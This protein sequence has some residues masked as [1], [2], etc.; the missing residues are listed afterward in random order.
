[1]NQTAKDY[2]FSRLKAGI[3]KIE[4]TLAEKLP[5]QLWLL[6]N[7][8]FK[9][10][11]LDFII[12]GGKRLRPVLS[13]IAAEEFGFV[14]EDKF[15]ELFL[16][17]ESFHKFIL[18]HDDI[19]DQD[20][21]RYGKPTVHAAV[22]E[23]MKELGAGDEIHFGHSIGI[24]AGDLM[25]NISIDHVLSAP[26]DA[27]VKVKLL[28]EMNYAFES[29]VYGWYKQFL[30]D[31]EPLLAMDLDYIIKF[32]LIRVTGKYTFTFP[33]KFGKTLATGD[34]KLSDNLELLCD[35]LGVL[36]QTGDDIIGIFGDPAETGKS[37]YGDIVQ[38]KKTVPMYYTYNNST[39]EEKKILDNLVGKKNIID[40]E[41]RQVR[42]IVEKNGLADS[43]ALMR[44]Y[45]AR[46]LE[47]L[48]KISDEITPD[49]RLFIQG[50]I[51]YLQERKH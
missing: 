2:F 21:V 13:M 7:D 24:I 50:F 8:I 20:D 11:S 46:C 30:T 45:A 9:T 37:N 15:N 4:D 33:I 12:N 23:K 48:E 38:A 39:D 16:T 26:I 6:E 42:D 18:T 17:L 34:A 10:K 47:L 41:A 40:A 28:K 31:Y 25:H 35:Y 1:M 29:V 32:N 44:D 22:R 5:H 49:F 27:E 3:K 51:E 36:F 19:I 43:Q 14:N